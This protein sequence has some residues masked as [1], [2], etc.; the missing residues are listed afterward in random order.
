MPKGRPVPTTR[1]RERKS[2]GKTG[3]AERG[4]PKKVAE[5][6]LA[7]IVVD[8]FIHPARKQTNDKEILID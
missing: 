3:P 5:P 2:K 8:L 6:N 1:K 7:P 4:G